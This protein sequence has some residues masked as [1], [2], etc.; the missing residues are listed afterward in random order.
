MCRYR[1]GNH[2]IGMG[3]C[4]AHST[5]HTTDIEL[6]LVVGF[7]DSCVRSN[8]HHVFWRNHIQAGAERPVSSLGQCNVN[9]SVHRT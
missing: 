9:S 2:R 8:L 5:V 6:T 7:L 1:D 3:A 4:V